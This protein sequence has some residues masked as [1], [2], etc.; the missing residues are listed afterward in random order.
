ML[1]SKGISNLFK[2]LIL[3]GISLLFLTCD[4]GLGKAV[5]TQAPTVAVEFPVTKS[6]LKGGF[7]MKGIATD[8]VK[9][10]DCFVTFKNMATSLEYKFGATV[11]NGEFTASINT[12]KEDGSFELP[13]G[14]YN[15][16]V[17]VSDA[18]RNSTVDVVYTIDNTAPTVLLTSPNSYSVS[19]WPNMY[20]T[21]SIKGEVYDRSNLESVTV[22]LVDEAGE[23]LKS[24]IADGT[25][26]FLAS[27]DTPFDE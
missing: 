13:D 21:F 18:Y 27:F 20:K 10:S 23:V 16:T 26:T 4:P 14:D 19:N 24:V 6:V 25:N 1:I 7:V 15:V 22:F 12:P 11:S 8:E 17:T 5:D 2:V 9:V 3:L